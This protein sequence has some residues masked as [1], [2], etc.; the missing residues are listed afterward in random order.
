[1]ALL[2]YG[3]A[4]EAVGQTKPTAYHN[5]TYGFT[6]TL[7]AGWRQMPEERSGTVRQRL[8]NPDVGYVVGFDSVNAEWPYLLVQGL[9]PGTKLPE[10]YLRNLAAESEYTLHEAIEKLAVP[11]VEHHNLTGFWTTGWMWDGEKEVA[12]SIVGSDQLLWDA[13]ERFKVLTIW[14]QVENGVILLLYYAAPDSQ[15]KAMLEQCVGILDGFHVNL[16]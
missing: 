1:L 8:N 4:T 14:K 16:L 15:T 13:G 3:S 2:L 10:G 5:A 6:L 11:S 9:D 12:W 7:P